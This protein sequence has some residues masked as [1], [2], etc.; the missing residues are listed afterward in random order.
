MASSSP[1]NTRAGPSK[2]SKSMPATLTTEPFGASEPCSTAMPPMSW[3]GS[4]NACTTS[5]SGA[6][7][8]ISSR[9]S[10]TVRR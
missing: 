4:D 1:S 6:G 3:I 8:S 10:A 2:W 9:F 5:P 7:G